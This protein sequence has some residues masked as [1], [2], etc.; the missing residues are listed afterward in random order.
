MQ[1]RQPCGF[2]QPER[3]HAVVDDTAPNPR[4]LGDL[5]AEPGVDRAARSARK[6]D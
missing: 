1:K 4:G 2:R 5:G 3:T 6:G